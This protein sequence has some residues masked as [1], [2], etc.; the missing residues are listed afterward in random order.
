MAKLWPNCYWYPLSV[1]R[2]R[3]KILSPAAP[4][5]QCASSAHVTMCS[6]GG[7]L[8]KLLGPTEDTDPVDTKLLRQGLDL[9]A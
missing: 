7:L 2:F 8:C 5:Q 4:N 3:A 1:L 6:P 9:R